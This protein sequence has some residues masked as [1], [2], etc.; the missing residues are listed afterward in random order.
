MAPSKSAKEGSKLQAIYRDA[1]QKRHPEREEVLGR[2][3]EIS[4]NDQVGSEFTKQLGT[5][6]RRAQK[7]PLVPPVQAGF[8]FAD[9]RSPLVVA[10]LSPEKCRDR[11]AECLQW[12]ES[13]S[14]LRVR[15]ILLDV[16]RIWTRLAIEAESSNCFKVALIEPKMAEGSK[17]FRR[18]PGGG[19]ASRGGVQTLVG[20]FVRGAGSN[21]KSANSWRARS[22]GQGNPSA[23]RY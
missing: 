23:F 6:R 19:T 7:T 14:S 1:R 5:R 8:Y 22:C 11:A 12:A 16:A 18:L 2:G 21:F 9:G 3:C 13:A 10:M 15:D 17:K 20:R 4:R